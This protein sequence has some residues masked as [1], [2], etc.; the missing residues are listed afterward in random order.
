MPKNKKGNN[1]QSKPIVVK[2]KKLEILAKSE[3]VQK[4]RDG[5]LKMS[6][7]LVSEII[8]TDAQKGRQASESQIQNALSFKGTNS[9][10]LEYI[11]EK[12]SF[13]LTTA[14]R[15]AL[16]DARMN[17]LVNHFA[18]EYVEPKSKLPHA[19]E[20]IRSTFEKMKIHPDYTVSFEKQVDEAYKKV[21]GTLMLKKR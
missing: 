7:V 13:N 14:E 15:R 16:N 17:A 12:G 9:E 19:P 21:L 18:S 8:Y 20:L 2:F 3:T 10:Y 4:Y 11:L 1:S 6:D 5:K